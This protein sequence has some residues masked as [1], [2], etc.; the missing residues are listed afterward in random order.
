MRVGSLSPLVVWLLGAGWSHPALAQQIST[1][2]PLEPYEPLENPPTPAAPTVPP[3]SLDARPGPP[4]VNEPPPGQTVA[5]TAGETPAPAPLTWYGWQSLL[6]DAAAAAVV[7]GNHGD[8]NSVAAGLVLFAAGGPTV[9][10]LHRE[11]GKAA[12]S[13]ALRTLVPLGLLLAITSPNTDGGGAI[14][15]VAPALEGMLAAAIFDSAALAWKG[16]GPR[17]RGHVYGRL[18]I[19]N[20]FSTDVRTAGA[21]GLGYRHEAGS[22]VL[23]VSAFNVYWGSGLGRGSDA[24]SVL[25]SSYVKVLGL[26]YLDR[27]I[28]KDVYVGGG[29]SYGEIAVWNP[30][31][32]GV[33]SSGRGPQTELVAGIE[34][35]RRTA[36]RTFIELDTTLPLYRVRQVTGVTAISEYAFTTTLSVGFGI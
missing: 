30:N 13:F 8:W 22:L 33:G 4:R 1:S 26:G 7:F 28:G 17:R 18:G 9:H 16:P 14:P 25:W 23:D 21:F 32:F 15:G 2:Q 24:S 5:P 36:V 29:V 35:L 11:P 12:L 3:G 10:L 20:A 34:L 19:L 31:A 27:L 6:V